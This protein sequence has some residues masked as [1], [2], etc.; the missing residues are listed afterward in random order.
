MLLRDLNST[1]LID[2]CTVLLSELYPR[3]EDREA[4]SQRFR[5]FMLAD[6]WMHKIAK[7][8][9]GRLVYESESFLP[10]QPVAGKPNLFMI[11]GN[12]TPESIALRAMYAYEGAASRQHRFWKVMHTT[13]VLRFSTG[14]P[15]EYSPAEKMARLYSGDYESP[16]N[17]HIMPFFSLASPPGGPW[18]G[19]SGLKKL[20]GRAFADIVTVE[21]DRIFQLLAEQSHKGDYVLVLQKDAY[22]ALRP[23]DGP[24]YDVSLLRQEPL[25]CHLSELDIEL[26]CIPPTRLLYSHVT[27]KALVGLTELAPPLPVTDT[28]ECVSG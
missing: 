23:G 28:P 3:A 17:L 5:T 22:M 13:G 4:F 27:R 9:N 18:G 1:G 10:P 19:V 12:P 26:L 11:V 7:V 14:E 24:P 20:F 15:D 16:F 21:R 25:R 8:R 2:S 6:D